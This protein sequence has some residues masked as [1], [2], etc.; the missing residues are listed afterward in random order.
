MIADGNRMR[1]TIL[2]VRCVEVSCD[3][4]TFGRSVFI[5]DVKRKIML[6]QILKISGIWMI[7]KMWGL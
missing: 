2:F 5:Q 7:L 6:W 3:L 1:S 4:E